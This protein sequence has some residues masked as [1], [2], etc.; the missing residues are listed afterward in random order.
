MKTASIHELKNELSTVPA[1]Q[2]MELCLRLAKF[3]KE[4]KELLTYLLFEA[5]DLEAYITAVKAYMDEEFD[6]LPKSSL[7][8]IKKALRKI[9]KSVNKYIKYAG[10]KQAEIELLIYFCSKIKQAGIKMESS[11]VLNNLFQ[12]QLKKIEKAIDSQHEDLQYDYR[13]QLEA[14]L[15]ARA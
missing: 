4:N 10:E 2:L 6:T 1:A 8:F 15:S 14:G 3:K 12:Q 5:H 7:Y 11:T 9:L 13:K